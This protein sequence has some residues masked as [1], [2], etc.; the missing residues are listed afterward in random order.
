VHQSLDFEPFARREEL[1][2]E[3]EREMS[4]PRLLGLATLGVGTSVALLA[5]ASTN[6]PAVSPP[7]SA[8]DTKHGLP[9][10]A[11]LVVGAKTTGTFV[12][13]LEVVSTDSNQCS[14]END[15]TFSFES[16]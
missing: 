10:G 14:L 12:V 3:G 8:S 15:P 2:A 16:S 13:G 1:H 9:L 6:V 5:S 7:T 11:P 4:W